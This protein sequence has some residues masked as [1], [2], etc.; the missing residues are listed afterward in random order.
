MKLQQT[1]RCRD[2]RANQWAVGGTRKPAHRCWFDCAVAAVLFLAAFSGVAQ[3][4]TVTAT[5]PM[6][7]IAQAIAINP[8]TNKIYLANGSHGVLVIDGATNATTKV[9]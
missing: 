3:A 2:R 7:G 6:D 9:A 1:T 8:A 4:Q 5:L